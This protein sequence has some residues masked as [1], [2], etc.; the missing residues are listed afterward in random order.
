MCSVSLSSN[1]CC[2]N[3]VEGFYYSQI[4]ILA[5]P[6]GNCDYIRRVSFLYSI[7]LPSTTLLLVF[8]VVALYKNNKYVVAFFALC[9]LAVLAL[10]I[11]VPMGTTGM[12]IKNTAY[13]VQLNFKPYAIIGA[14]AP[15][16]HDALIFV[17]TAWAFLRNSY[18]EPNL[19]NSYNVIVL[20]KHLPAFSK[21]LLRDG[22][23][24]IL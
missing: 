24:Y 21:S 10:S 19:K 4:R 1:V 11:V 7:A 9:W 13:C 17:A 23:L 12:Q 14:I 16:V 22:Q 2:F 15:A 18:M 8:R 3:S 6:I 20:G 5:A